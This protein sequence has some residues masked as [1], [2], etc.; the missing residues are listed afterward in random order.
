MNYQSESF[1][2][3]VRVS[4]PG[5]IEFHQAVEEVASSLIPI[6]NN[7]FPRYIENKIL[8]RMI[9]PERQII[10]RVTWVDDNNN[11]HINKGFRVEFNSALGPY[12]GGLKFHNLKIRLTLRIKI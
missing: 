2:E 9:E 10:F 3:Q 6:L 7:H 12:K 11:I 4:N 8:E 1:I 5:E